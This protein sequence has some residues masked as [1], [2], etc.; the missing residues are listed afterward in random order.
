MRTETIY[1]ALFDDEAFAR[2]PDLL[3][4]AAAA[5]SAMIV[6]QHSTGGG[7][8]LAY[9]YF[10]NGGWVESYGAFAEVDPYRNLALSPSN[11]NR[12]ILPNERISRE[13]FE[14]SVIFN[15]LVR[16]SG[17]DTVY[18]MGTGIASAWGSGVVGLHRGRNAK[19]FD[20]N[21]MRRAEPLIMHVERVVR[22]RGEIASARRAAAFAQNALD[23]AGLV[24]ITVRAGGAILHSNEGAERI[25]ERG[26][27]FLRRGGKLT[28]ASA[29]ASRRLEAALAQATAPHHPAASALVVERGPDEPAYLAT[30]TPLVGQV[31]Q[32]A[33]LI[34]FRDPGIVHDGVAERLRALF[35][36]TNAE[37]AVVIDLAGGLALRDIARNRAV[38]VSTL[39]SQLK[40]VARKT[41]CGR[42]A[43]L[44]A[45]IGRIVP[46][47]GAHPPIG[48]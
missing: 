1:E 27:G 45:L 21:D 6:W 41:G 30:V 19:P 8:A 22:A 12:V 9:N 14:R 23:A 42:Q 44:V 40:S 37:A 20:E 3:C 48:A 38:Q 34:L 36:L 39:R 33:A 43:E 15:E 31:S 13:A 24:A 47:A 16:K 10:H 18:C 32:P 35:G 17:D 5:R 25:F 29:G 26:D 28:A 4:K 2:L 11:L 7:D 46:L